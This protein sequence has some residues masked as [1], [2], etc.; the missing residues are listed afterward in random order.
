MKF[1]H[2]ISAISFFIL[3]AGAPSAAWSQNEDTLEILSWLECDKETGECITP[4]ILKESNQ[5]EDDYDDDEVQNADDN[6]LL[7]PNTS[8]SDIDD[9]N[10]GDFC[11]NCPNHEN[12]SQQDMDLDGVGDVCD[13][14]ADNDQVMENI[15]NQTDDAGVDQGGSKYDNCPSVYN[16]EQQD[17]DGDGFG[18]ACDDDIDDDGT[19][20]FDDDCPYGN[21]SQGSEVCAGDID[22]DGVPD[23]DL[24]G[25][26][27]TLMDNCRATANQNQSDIDGDEIGDVCDLDIDDDG[28][29]NYQDNCYRCAYDVA[30]LWD[31]DQ[32]TDTSNPDQDDFD[33]DGVGADCDDYFCYVVLS[34]TGNMGDEEGGGGENGEDCFDPLEPFYVATPNAVDVEYGEVVRL[35]LFANRVNSA[36]LYEWRIT[37]SPQAGAGEIV[38]DSGATGYSTP[39]EY[40]YENGAEPILYPYADGRYEVTVRVRQVFEDAVSGEVGLEDEA[41]AVVIV[42]GSNSAYLAD[43]DCA[44]VGAG[45]QSASGIV[46]LAFLVLFC[47]VLRKC[48]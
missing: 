46:F 44:L 31:C 24:T 48:V 40:Q 3:L 7:V 30:S 21:I 5:Q 25:S 14:D 34:L 35:R 9:D 27:N 26:T 20:N 28:V 1:I 10:V 13:V 45:H 33:R 36:L 41:R 17:W 16:P 19:D 4:D 8:Q 12:L 42:S 22:G 38:N 2:I 18:D 23:F 15:Y 32:F 6:C 29:S 43:C 47:V 39:F 37:D 11:D